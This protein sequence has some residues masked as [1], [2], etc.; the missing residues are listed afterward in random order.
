MNA[1]DVYHCRVKRCTPIE[2]VWPTRRLLLLL[3]VLFHFPTQEKRYMCFFPLAIFQQFLFVNM[4]Y[5]FV[6]QNSPMYNY[7]SPAF[8]FGYN[9][10]HW[11]VAQHHHALSL[12][13]L[14]EIHSTYSPS[15]VVVQEVVHLQN[16]PSFLQTIGATRHLEMV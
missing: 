7:V 3:L 11:D 5:L 12:S 14:I 13:H 1:N 16:D 2:I 6:Q 8:S 10:Q 4:G 15:N 9:T